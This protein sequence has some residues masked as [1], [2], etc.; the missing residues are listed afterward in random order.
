MTADRFRVD[1]LERH[2]AVPVSRGVI[3]YRL[4]GMQHAR[5]NVLMR[6]LLSGNP[7]LFPNASL[8]LQQ[9]VNERRRDPGSASPLRAS[10]A[11]TS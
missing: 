4:T 6:R 7:S 10:R 3:P 9:Q 5:Q 2:P 8:S 1:G 11:E